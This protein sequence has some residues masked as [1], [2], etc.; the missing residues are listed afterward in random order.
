[1][2]FHMGSTRPL[3]VYLGMY[4]GMWVWYDTTRGIASSLA[5]MM[6]EKTNRPGDD[7]WMTSGRLVT[8]YQKTLMDSPRESSRVGDL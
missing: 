4:S 1:M 5:Y 6:A 8:K 7:T 3:H 2:T